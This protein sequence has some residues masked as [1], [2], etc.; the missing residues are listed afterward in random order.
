M[1]TRV[2]EPALAKVNL[3]LHVTGRR[4][5]GYHLLDSLVVFADC[6][7]RVRAE[8]CDGPAE[9]RVTGPLADGVPEDETNIVLKAA[10]LIKPLP[11]VSFHLH[12][13]LPM[14]AGIGGGSSD[15]A[16]ALRVLT[17]LTGADLP[18][19][20]K[21]SALG[22]DIPV[23]LMSKPQ[24]MRS[25]G[26]HLAD[27]TTL[28]DFFLL[29]VN[30]GIA[31]PT[32]KVFSAMSRRR[33][34]PMEPVLPRWQDL[35]EFADWL[36]TQRNDMEDAACALAPAIHEVLDAIVRQPGCLMARMSGSGATC[37]GIFENRVPA[38]AGARELSKMPG[39]WVHAAP[40]AVT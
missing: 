33:N 12:K 29:L 23:C 31:L 13:T 40:A 34:A 11:R 3:S 21:I 32:G 39:W 8:M 6:G 10:A 20:A 1:L 16:A 24:R 2:E 15:A 4:A 27:I 36:S 38:E 9:L 17:K 30:P 7:E 14:E 35:S 26:E 5:D 25:I 28:P 19:L 18:P 37:F 22:A